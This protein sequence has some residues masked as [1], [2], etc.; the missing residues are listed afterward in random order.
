MIFISEGVGKCGGTA[1][2]GFQ[3]I[4]GNLVSRRKVF[5]TKLLHVSYL[6]NSALLCYSAQKIIIVA[7]FFCSLA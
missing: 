5:K 3:K 2:L 6:I 4:W 7:F 1:E